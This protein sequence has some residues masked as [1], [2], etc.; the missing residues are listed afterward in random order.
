FDELSEVYF[1][2]L[3]KN[4][5]QAAAESYQLMSNLIQEQEFLEVS[6]LVADVLEKSV[7][8]ERYELE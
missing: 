2:G 8:R 5:T 6:D 1:I 7:Y 4:V 3:S